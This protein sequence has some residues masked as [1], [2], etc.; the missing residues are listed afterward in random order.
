MSRPWPTLDGL[1]TRII[2]HRGASGPLPEHTAPAYALALEQGA[3]VL[4]PDLVPS[5]DDVLV[6][7]HD[8]GLRRS[9]DVASR[10]EF[11]AR[12]RD[13]DWFVDDF[14]RDELDALRAIQPFGQRD[15]SHDGRH[16]L[17][18]F[19]SLVA[20]AAGE[21]ERRARPVPLY[22]E[23]KHPA[24]FLAAGRDIVAAFI[25]ATRSHDRSLVPLWLQC[26]EVEA[27]HR[28][29]AA[30]GLP[31]HLLLDEQGDWRAAIEAHEGWLAGLGVAKSLLHLASG[32]SSGLVEAAH[33]R[34]LGVHAWTY[35][36]DRLPPGRTKVED[37]LEAAFALGVDAVFCDFPAT[38]LAC[39]AR[40]Q[41]T[42]G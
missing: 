20:W 24:A 28:L 26:F 38:A 2:A 11:A 37:E 42:S 19:A 23:L 29:H 12:E 27:L 5:R 33:A 32:G 4:E 21:A 34:G 8:R 13:G 18:D 17:L 1:P 15:R 7:R 3:D 14:D 9:T 30:T 25:A 22:P 16:A 35:R 31:S 41:A 39:R 40:W 6:V 36:D 10:R